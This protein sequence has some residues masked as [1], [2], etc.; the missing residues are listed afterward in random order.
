MINDAD[1][2]REAA[3]RIIDGA[4]VP[5]GP[6]GQYRDGVKAWIFNTI[7]DQCPFKPGVEYWEAPQEGETDYIKQTMIDDVKT[8][9]KMCYTNYHSYAAACK[10]L[11]EQRRKS[12]AKIDALVALLRESKRAHTDQ[13]DAF[14]LSDEAIDADCT[15]G[16]TLWNARVDA[17][18]EGHQP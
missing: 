7:A 8:L 6:S 10:K 4:L 3:D 2:M 9:Q 17:T 16:A 12:K 15:C 14:L 13:C 11:G 18:L 5:I 1:W